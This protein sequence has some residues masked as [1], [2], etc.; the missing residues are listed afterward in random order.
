M[1]LNKS[2]DIQNFRLNALFYFAVFALSASL[3]A[4]FILNKF[5]TATVPFQ[6][7]VFLAPSL[8]SIAQL[9]AEPVANDSLCNSVAGQRPPGKYS[10]HGPL[11][12]TWKYLPSDCLSICFR[13]ATNESCEP[14]KAAFFENVAQ[15]DGSSVSLLTASIDF[16]SSGSSDGTAHVKVLPA[17]QRTTLLMRYVFRADVPGS[18]WKVIRNSPS[19]FEGT[20]V[21]ATTVFVDKYGNPGV[22]EP[23]KTDEQWMYLNVGEMWSNVSPTE[24]GTF[25][26]LVKGETL[27]VQAHCYTDWLDLTDSIRALHVTPTWES[28]V[29]LVE[30]APV[31]DITV[32]HVT[33]SQEGDVTK[34]TTTLG[35][36]IIARAGSG[37]ARFGSF[38]EAYIQIAAMVVLFGI[39]RVVF[40][41][42]ACYILGSLSKVYKRV[43]VEPFNLEEHI[44][45]YVQGLLTTTSNFRHLVDVHHDHHVGIS[46][47]KL[48]VC[49]QQMVPGCSSGD[50]HILA[51][52]FLGQVQRFTPEALLPAEAGRALSGDGF[53]TAFFECRALN[54]ECVK[55]LLDDNRRRYFIEK[56]FTPRVVKNLEEHF[57]QNRHSEIDTNVDAPR[58]EPSRVRC[59]PSIIVSDGG[60]EDTLAADVLENVDDL[61][62]SLESCVS[63]QQLAHANLH[64]AQEQT[65]AIVQKLQDRTSFL[66][67]CVLE[68]KQ[69]S[70][71]VDDLI[72]KL[73]DEISSFKSALA[74]VAKVQEQNMILTSTLAERAPAPPDLS[75]FEEALA[76]LA[77]AQKHTNEVMDEIQKNI[78]ALEA[79]PSNQLWARISKLANKDDAWNGTLLKHLSTELSSIRDELEGLRWKVEH[80][81][82]DE[83]QAD[84]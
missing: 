59:D 14:S 25:D 73:R 30:I 54:H 76:G 81:G 34:R 75:K 24:S 9:A 12:W 21:Q 47:H 36:R 84:A 33:A 27:S 8:D 16:A 15:R 32:M 5:Y 79:E 69:K 13:G 7:Q 64:R 42:I 29:C 23:S 67:K 37:I 2:V 63:S 60:G 51:E 22:V 57:V 43:I 18:L 46:I 45:S 77:S 50:A 26:R 31:D 53:N 78:A 58:R 56:L 49:I 72:Q 83:S 71:S 52:Y 80:S 4:R 3:T 48:R 38:S 66:L 55:T 82:D 74:D 40:Q 10:V 70:E 1:K 11:G 68:E 44:M 39:P 20:Q 35:L 28:P 6:V 19:S 41:V 62:E 17:I 65:G 61:R